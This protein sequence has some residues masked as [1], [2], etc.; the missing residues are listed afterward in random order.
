MTQPTYTNAFVSQP[1]MSSDSEEVHTS[2]TYHI[3][4]VKSNSSSM[5]AKLTK[6]ASWSDTIVTRQ[7]VLHDKI[8]KVCRKNARL[9]YATVW[10]GWRNYHIDADVVYCGIPKTG[11]SS[12]KAMLI[13]LNHP[14]KYVETVHS[15]FNANH[16]DFAGKSPEQ[17]AATMKSHKSFMFVRHPLERIASTYMDKLGDPNSLGDPFKNAFRK[18]EGCPIIK[19]NRAN[20]KPQSRKLCN[21]VTFGEFVNYITARPAAMNDHWMP[22]YKICNPCL[23]DFD[24]IGSVENITSDKRYVLKNIFKEKQYNMPKRHASLRSYS[25]MYN[26]IPKKKMEQLYRVYNFDFELFGY[27]KNTNF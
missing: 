27:A 25:R 20:P 5:K 11:T 23:F 9:K 2:V 1:A 26:D 15:T 8:A 16:A 6:N 19:W 10:Q 21:D 3:A 17:R 7:R 24:F 22:Q 18:K 12:W 13:K 14:H 4:S